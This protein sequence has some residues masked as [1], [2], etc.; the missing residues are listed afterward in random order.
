MFDFDLT[1]LAIIATGV[2]LY[3]STI[4]FRCSRCANEHIINTTRQYGWS[5]IIFCLAGMAD[6]F[7]NGK[8]FS[9]PIELY[10]IFPGIFYAWCR[11]EY[12]CFDCMKFIPVN[13]ETIR[14]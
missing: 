6:D 13:K 5:W 9:W 12:F 1:T 4:K 14:D 7:L 8:S 3:F 10:L 11:P 2:W